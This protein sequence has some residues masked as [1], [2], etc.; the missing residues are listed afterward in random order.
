MKSTL[1]LLVSAAV[2]LAG[3]TPHLRIDHEN[4]P[5]NGCKDAAITLGP[6]AAGVGSGQPLY[7]VFQD[8]STAG[9]V[10]IRSDI[11][12]QKSTDGGRMWLPADVLVRRGESHATHPD[13]ATD[14]DGD[15]YVV[16]TEQG[17]S[18]EYVYCVQSTDDGA[19]WSQPTR[20]DDKTRGGMG[21]PRIAADSAGNLLCAWNDQRTGSLHIWSSV[22]TDRGATW[23]QN[24]RVDD[25]TTD[26]DCYQADVFVQPGTN[27]YLVAAEAPY[28]FGSAGHLGSYLYRSTD[29]GQTFQP[30]VRLDTFTRAN[31]DEPHIVADLQHGICTNTGG[32]AEA[33]TLYVQPDTWG[34]P[35]FIG[36]SYVGPSLAISVDG[37]AHAALMVNCDTSEVIYLPY[38]SRSSD[39]GVSWSEPELVNDD[40]TAN[41]W[42]PDI[43]ADSAGH[44]YVVWQVGSGEVWFSTNNPAAIAEETSNAELRAPNSGPTVIRNVLFLPRDM[45]E[46]RSG[47]SDRV[48][49]PTLLDIGGRKLMD[50][51][52]GANDVRALA[53]G[54]YFVRQAASVKRDASSVTKVVVTR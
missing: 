30:G 27:Y 24:V 32:G 9:I 26:M 11:M 50:L 16:Y 14:P 21:G 45:T 5:T 25:D 42:Y 18:G 35:H 19:T 48:P 22:S 4:K 46:I 34:A 8:D 7:V 2:A 39:H 54:V 41:S 40:T 36:Y 49:R 53:P 23:N 31:A 37:I 15:I 13:I 51:K 47:I 43:A 3:F 12:F 1:L 29:R 6:S 38:Y 52:P 10:V 20:V 28:Y 44:A 17:G 33:R